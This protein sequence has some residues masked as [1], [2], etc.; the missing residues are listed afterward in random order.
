MFAGFII[1]K[2]GEMV[3]LLRWLSLEWR[4]LGYLRKAKRCRVRILAT[5]YVPRDVFFAHLSERFAKSAGVLLACFMLFLTTQCS[6][7][8]VCFF[9]YLINGAQKGCA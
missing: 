3:R 7:T 4:C 1:K 8:T 2:N 5:P 9:G 6:Y